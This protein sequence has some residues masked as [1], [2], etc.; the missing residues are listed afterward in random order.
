[1]NSIYIYA[2][3]LMVS[4]RVK[5]YQYFTAIKNTKK[6]LACGWFR[7][8]IVKINIAD[9]GNKMVSFVFNVIPLDFTKLSRCFLYK[10]VFVN[11]L[12]KRSLPFAKK[13]DANNKKG[14]VGNIGSTTP[15]APIPVQINANMM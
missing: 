2:S 12:W 1:M 15:T 3:S 4:I 8:I 14:V 10:L 7:K 5:K 6:I 13:N 11:H 9:T